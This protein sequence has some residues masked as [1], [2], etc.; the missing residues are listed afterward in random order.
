MMEEA[1]ASDGGAR[2][3]R[4]REAGSS[5][6]S[7]WKKERQGQKQR[8]KQKQKQKQK[9]LQRQGQVQMQMRE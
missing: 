4:A 1:R 3:S 9:Q 5:R 7:E 2:A 6:C 8:Q